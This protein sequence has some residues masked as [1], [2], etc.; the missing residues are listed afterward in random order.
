M[1][2][3]QSLRH[4]MAWLAICSTCLPTTTF[5]DGAACASNCTAKNSRPGLLI[6]DVALSPGGMLVGQILD[7]KMQPVSG[8]EVS[9]QVGGQSAA[10]TT[11]DANGVFAVAGLRGGVHQVAA[12]QSVANCRLWAPGTAPPSAESSLRLIP[13]QEQLVRGQY[14]GNSFSDRMHAW[15]TNPW[16]VGGVIVTAIAVPV[17]LNNLD[18]DDDNGS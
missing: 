3:L 16:I 17:A 10:A 18:D 14:P 15:A 11:T 12:Q 13:G 2:G 8:T 5:A 7:E 4:G 1:N 9:V 6:R